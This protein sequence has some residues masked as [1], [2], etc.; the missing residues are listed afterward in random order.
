VWGDINKKKKS[1][2]A[3]LK[4]CKA[5][6]LGGLLGFDNSQKERV[7]ER[8]AKKKTNAQKVN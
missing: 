7:N 1:I 2:I 4:V 8:K 6:R 5:V 3:G